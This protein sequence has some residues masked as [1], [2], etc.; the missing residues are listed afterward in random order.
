MSDKKRAL[1]ALAIANGCQCWELAIRLIVKA[2]LANSILE[3][4]RLIME[5]EKH[6]EGIR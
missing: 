4:D 1:Q 5:G 6:E 3:A 2:G